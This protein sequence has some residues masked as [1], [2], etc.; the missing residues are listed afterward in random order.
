MT[1]RSDITDILERS[2]LSKWGWADISG[3]HELGHEYPA[4][5]SLAAAYQKPVPYDVAAYRAILSAKQD[6]I[7]AAVEDLVRYFR[8]HNI[9]HRAIPQGGQNPATLRAEFPHKLAAT[10]AGLGWIGKNSLLVTHEFGPRVKLAT[11]L[12]ARDMEIR[13][14]IAVSRCGLCDICVRACPYGY[15]KGVEWTPGIPREH[16]FQPFACSQ[17][18]EAFI[19]VLGYKHECGYCLLECPVGV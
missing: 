11:V 4:A 7:D 19:P 3:Y 10:L 18:R 15:I 12:L 13:N 9:G 5:I 14:T 2:P 16:L 6:I 17:K 1:T 8:E